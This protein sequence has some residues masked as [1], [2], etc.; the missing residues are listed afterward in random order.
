MTKV[1]SKLTYDGVL[2]KAYFLWVRTP[3]GPRPQKMVE[4]DWGQYDWLQAHVIGLYPLS[5]E[6]IDDP[7]DE[8]AKRYPPPPEPQMT[9][10][11]R[12]KPWKYEEPA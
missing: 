8:L 4:L 10:E 6:E 5:A 2:E 11:Q 3:R 1:V 7:L 12:K 9:I